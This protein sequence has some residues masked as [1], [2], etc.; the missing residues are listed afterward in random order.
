MDLVGGHALESAGPG[1]AARLVADHLD[2][3][4]DRHV[5][6]LAH[7][8]HLDGARQVLRALNLLALLPCSSRQWKLG[9]VRLSRQSDLSSL[10]QRDALAEA[11]V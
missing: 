9:A 5:A 2:L 4:D 11:T 6:A 10:S 7:V 1:P 3:V 8:D